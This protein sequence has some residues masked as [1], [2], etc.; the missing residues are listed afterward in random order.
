M[1]K[2]FVT[3][4]LDEKKVDPTQP[5][6]TLDNDPDVIDMEGQDNKEEEKTYLP[7]QIDTVT[8]L[9]LLLRKGTSKGDIATLVL[10]C[11]DDDLGEMFTLSHNYIVEDEEEIQNLYKVP[12]FEEN[13]FVS[14]KIAADMI[15]RE[16]KSYITD[17]QF[18][19]EKS[20]VPNQQFY[21]DAVRNSKEDKDIYRFFMSPAVFTCIAYFDDFV[22]NPYENNHDVVLATTEGFLK[23]NAP[24][25]VFIVDRVDKIIEMANTNVGNNI[26]VVSKLMRYTAD[27]AESIKVLSSYELEQ[28]FNKKKFKDCTV[29]KLEENFTNDA[30]QYLTDFMTFCHIKNIDKDYDILR[31]SNKNK[32]TKIIFMDMDIRK[33][34]EEMIMNY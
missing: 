6:D 16:E 11:K 24:V 3:G 26:A 2:T 23:E 15:M 17:F 10:L 34:L 32:E 9:T 7:R 5:I 12:F 20:N 18:N 28:K 8:P 13:N 21:I 14:T 22:C 29:Q 27:A 19:Y 31:V 4:L 33:E 30:D 25:D 1:I